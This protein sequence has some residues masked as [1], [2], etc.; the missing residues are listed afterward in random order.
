MYD[1]ATKEQFIELR[2]Q[3]KSFVAIAGQLGVSKPTLITWAHQNRDRLDNLRQFQLEAMREQYRLG[4]ERQ[5]EMLSKQ[6][7]AVETELGKR[8]LAEVPTE[9]LYGLLFK[10]LGQA[11][12]EDAPL[13]L[14]GDSLFGDT[15]LA[16]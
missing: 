4:K 11:K 15:S 6:L 16:L 2:A 14:K 9:R 1:S 13:A 5:L 12:S 8:T 10:L 3:G 7:D